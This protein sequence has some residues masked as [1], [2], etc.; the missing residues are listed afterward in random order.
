MTSRWRYIIHLLVIYTL[1]LAGGVLLIRLTEIKIE[2]GAYIGLLS[3]MAMISLGAYLLV[4]A[5]TKRKESE[6]GIILL[7]GIG[8]K[9]LAYLIMILFFWISGRNFN[10][11]FIITFFVLYLVFTIY[12][13]RILY[14]TLK[15]N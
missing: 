5:G 3:L 13:I 11:E 15:T 9:F 6:R 4:A 1:L 8:G 12:L 14:K 2:E 7:A 10:A